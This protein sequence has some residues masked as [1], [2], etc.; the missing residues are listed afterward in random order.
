MLKL[1][2]KIAVPVVLTNFGWLTSPLIVIM[3]ASRMNDPVKLAVVGLSSSICN[4]VVLSVLLGL[5]AAQDTL[6]SQA[7]G[8]GNLELCGTYLNR[9]CM[10]MLAFFV[11]LAM[12]AMLFAEGIFTS[13]GIAYQ[14]HEAISLGASFDL[15]V[16][17]FEAEILTFL[18]DP[19]SMGPPEA[20]QYSRGR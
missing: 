14:P 17:R 11:P 18:A 2:T 6:T 8:A 7:F 1:F 13:L 12:I 16:G 20:P 5:N 4:I 3:I 19:G 15:L 10:V 9:G